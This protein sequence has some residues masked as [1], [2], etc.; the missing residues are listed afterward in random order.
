MPEGEANFLADNVVKWRRGL[1]STDKK[2]AGV[3][4]F[5]SIEDVLQVEGMSRTLF[6][7]MRDYIVV[8]N[9]G[10]T[11]TDWTVAPEFLL[12]VLEN[13]NPGGVDAVSGRRDK[14]TRSSF[15]SGTGGQGTLSG[16]YRADA[17]VSYG[18]QVWLRR[19]WVSVGSGSGSRLP[20]HFKR[21]EPPRVYGQSNGAR[22]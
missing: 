13:T 1:S 5:Q 12:R 21:T 20:W 4:S 9:W 14:M 22:E 7:A 17:V 3:K 18:D 19:R 2:R 15:A 6:D 16:T 8:G 10:G 11:V